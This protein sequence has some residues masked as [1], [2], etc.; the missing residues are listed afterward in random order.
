MGQSLTSRTRTPVKYEKILK[1]DT[2]MND[3]TGLA[4]SP[5]QVPL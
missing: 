5:D 2:R 3:S 4:M 1:N